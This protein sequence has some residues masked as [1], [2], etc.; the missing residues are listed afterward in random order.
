MAGD[1]GAAHHAH[2]VQIGSKCSQ[3]EKITFAIFLF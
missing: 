2:S 3:R 1:G